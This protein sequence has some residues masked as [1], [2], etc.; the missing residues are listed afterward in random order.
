[1]PDTIGPGMLEISYTETEAVSI[2]ILQHLQ[3]RNVTTLLGS[4]GAML[5]VGKLFN[6]GR[7]LTIPQEIKFVQDMSTWVEAYWGADG[8]DPKEMN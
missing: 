4:L 5:T 8:V 7:R 3:S 1:M 6:T 2:G